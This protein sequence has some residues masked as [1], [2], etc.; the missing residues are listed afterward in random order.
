MAS[1]Q[2]IQLSSG[3]QR[4]RDVVERLQRSEVVEPISVR[5]LLSWF[6]AERRGY[7][8]VHEIKS[9]LDKAALETVP[10]FEAV[11][12]D[13]PIEFRLK[14]KNEKLSNSGAATVQHVQGAQPEADTPATAPA[15]TDPTLRISRLAAAN[16]T[17]VSVKP[18]VPIN[19]AVPQMFYHDYSQLPVMTSEREVKG[20]ISWTSIGSKLASGLSGAHV[21]NLMEPA[22]EIEAEMSLFDAIPVIVKHQYVLVR[23]QDRRITGIV[24]SSDLGVQFRQLAEP[25]LLLG[26]I[27]NQIR[28]VLSSA[29]LSVDQLAEAKDPNDTSRTITSVA[30]LSF[31]EY[32]RLLQRQDIWDKAALPVDRTIFCGLLEEIRQIRNDVMH[33]DPDGIAPEALEKLRRATLLFQ[34]LRAID[35]AKKGS[36]PHR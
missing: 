28:D 26:E 2:T 9:A 22:V 32:I 24:T 27:E 23:G 8:V 16:K 13:T 25:F 14:T 36:S 34:K 1:E 7:W 20:M 30:D 31:G 17:L 29:Q 6:Y 10:D 12:I 3:D 5:A 18:D 11:Y 19:E 15:T 33:F 35:D 4:L 21:R